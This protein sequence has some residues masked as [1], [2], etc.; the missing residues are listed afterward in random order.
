MVLQAV[1]SMGPGWPQLA[2]HMLVALITLNLLRKLLGEV[3]F[4]GLRL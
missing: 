1:P 3:R 4:W 2:A